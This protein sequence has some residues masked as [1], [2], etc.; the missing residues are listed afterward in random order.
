VTFQDGKP[1]GAM[2][3]RIVRGGHLAK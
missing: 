1:T 3:G 2:P